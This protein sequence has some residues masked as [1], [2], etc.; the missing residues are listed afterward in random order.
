MSKTSVIT[1]R[2][3]PDIAAALDQLAGRVGRSRASLV[4]EAVA[5]YAREQAAFLDFVEEGERDIADGRVHDQPDM[6]RWLDARIANARTE[7]EKRAKAA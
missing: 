4:A 7:S 6:E 2:V 5:D 3:D 1:A